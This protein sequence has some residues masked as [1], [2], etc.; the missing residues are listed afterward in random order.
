MKSY[1]FLLLLVFIACDVE[2]KT[3]EIVLKDIP[4]DFLNKFH[5]IIEGC[6]G[7]FESCIA[8]KYLDLL[9]NLSREELEEIEQFALSPECYGDCV[10]IMKD[11]IKDEKILERECINLCKI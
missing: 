6:G 5:D 8:G 3:D 9:F 4:H 11:V 2:E 7:F 10:E 1:L